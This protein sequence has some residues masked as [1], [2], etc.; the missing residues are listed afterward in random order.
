MSVSGTVTLRL[1]CELFL[2]VDSIPLD[3]WVAPPVSPSGLDEVA[4]IYAIRRPSTWPLELRS[5]VPRGFSTVRR[6]R[7]I[8]R[9][10]IGYASGASP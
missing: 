4:L 10:A 3:G 2:P 1:P 7:I 8:N 6:G 5:G 9:L